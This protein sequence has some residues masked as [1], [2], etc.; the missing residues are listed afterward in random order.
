MNVQEQAW[1][2][3]ADKSPLVLQFDSLK[4][5]HIINPIT[6]VETKYRRS[7]NEQMGLVK[8]EHVIE[9]RNGNKS[10]ESAFSLGMV[11][12]DSPQA[13][14][15]RHLS[16]AEKIEAMRKFFNDKANEA[17]L[18]LLFDNP[19]QGIGALVIAMNTGKF[20]VVKQAKE[21]K[22]AKKEKPVKKVKPAKEVKRK[23][24]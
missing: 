7:T 11:A 15:V 23:K 14:R 1:K 12:A 6:I 17:Q 5:F 19:S 13:N 3:Y 22:P 20:I 8:N 2:N 16:G 10:V 21:E 4:G 18:G 9:I 24:K